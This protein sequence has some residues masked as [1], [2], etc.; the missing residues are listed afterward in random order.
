MSLWQPLQLETEA[1]ASLSLA[2]DRVG[3]A[4]HVDDVEAEGDEQHDGERG[5]DGAQQLE[6]AHVARLPAAAGKSWS[7]FSWV[8]THLGPRRLLVGR[9]LLHVGLDVG[10]RAAQLL[11]VD[12]QLAERPG[13]LRGDARDLRVGVDRRLA[14]ADQVVAGDA[15][16]AR[17][18]CRCRA[19]PCRS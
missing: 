9:Q 15:G 18:R 1:M 17:R 8:S 11:V 12:D 7:I 10:Q 19:A 5:V 16:R 14:D 4:E 13:V 2:D 6:A 3:G